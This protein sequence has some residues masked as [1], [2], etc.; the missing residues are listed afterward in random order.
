MGSLYVAWK[1]EGGRNHHNTVERMITPHG[2]STAYN[3]HDGFEV[4]ASPHE[5]CYSL[6]MISTTPPPLKMEHLLVVVV[7]AA[8]SSGSH[9]RPIK[10]EKETILTDTF[11]PPSSLLGFMR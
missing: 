11:P 9:R 6:A 8:R 10:V 5:S 4:M 2:N 3:H 7:V 1:I